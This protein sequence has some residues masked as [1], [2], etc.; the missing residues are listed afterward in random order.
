VGRE[1][2]DCSPGCSADTQTFHIFQDILLF[3]VIFRVTFLPVDAGA[4]KGA[5]VVLRERELVKGGIHL[6][7]AVKVG[8]LVGTRVSATGVS[9]ITIKYGLGEQ[10]VLL[11][12][13]IPAGANAHCRQTLLQRGCPDIAVQMHAEDQSI[14][15]NFLVRA[16]RIYSLAPQAG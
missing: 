10:A 8:A 16:G 15:I 4:R 5:V 12:P 3:D 2:L 13:D 1:R 11:F 7:Y 14:L 6:S 9:L